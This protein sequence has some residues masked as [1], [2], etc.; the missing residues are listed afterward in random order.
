MAKPQ[1]EIPV[2]PG[3]R[4]DIDVETQSASG[5]G[6]GRASGYTLFLPGGL[7]GD[8]VRAEIIKRTPRFGVG[9]V[10]EVLSPSPARVAAPCPV[11]T[12]C[13]GCKLQEQRYE[14][15]LAFKTRV[16][17]DSLTHLGNIDAFP[18]ITTWAAPRPYG[19]RNKASFAVTLL[20]PGKL[21]I[22]FFQEGSHD[23]ADSATCDILQAPINATKEWLRGLLEKHR[24]PIYNETRHKGFLRGLIVRHAKSPGETLVGFV[25]TRG[26]LPKPFLKEA[27]NEAALSR[28][29]I[30]GLVQNLNERDTNAILGPKTRVL[31]GKDRLAETV[32]DLTLNLSLGSFFQVNTEQAARLYGLAREWAASLG[33]RVVDAYSGVGGIA[34]G[35]A[36]AGLKVTGIEEY[37]PAVADAEE[38][39]RRNGIDTA[40]F[41]AGTVEQHLPQLIGEGPVATLVVDPPRK[42]C[43]P[44]VLEAAKTMAPKQIIYISCNPATLARDLARL[45]DYRIAQITVIDMF[46]QTQ[47]VETA[48]RLVPAG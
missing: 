31:W 44:A 15:Q 18:E 20:A 23:V 9:R 39:A 27:L 29:G 47:H 3:D 6:I 1:L 37:A 17:A 46:P 2:A 19:Y 45:P 36:R 43:S 28:F 34:L 4:L 5:D 38:N 42:G 30:T 21:G 13:G 16:V 26:R 41:L 33:G 35:I 25:T 10:I 40:R 12:A 32:G 22:G 11:F 8:Q 14:D 48:V 7:P 24:V